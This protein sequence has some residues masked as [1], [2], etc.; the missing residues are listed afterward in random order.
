MSRTLPRSEHAWEVW[1]GWIVSGVGAWGRSKTVTQ[2]GAILLHGT[3]RLFVNRF[4]G[5]K[6]K[7]QCCKIPL[8]PGRKNWS[9]CSEFRLQFFFCFLSGSKY[10]LI[11]IKGETMA[12]SWVHSTLPCPRSKRALLLRTALT[13]GLADPGATLSSPGDFQSNPEPGNWAA[14]SL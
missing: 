2:K 4:P 14:K 11:I 6:H 7:Y 5:N 1:G 10:F 12:H 8:S 3:W 13:Q 9:S